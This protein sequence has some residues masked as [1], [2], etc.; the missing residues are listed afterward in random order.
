MNLP[1]D[2]VLESVFWIMAG[3]F[4]I[5]V[6]FL[7]IVYGRYAFKKAV[8]QP[9]GDMPPL[10]VVICAKN[11]FHNLSRNLPLI[12]DQN[13]PEYEVVVVDDASDDETLFYLEELK[14]KHPNL[15]V[16]RIDQDVN[17]FRGKKFPLSLGIKSAK[18]EYLLLTDADCTPAGRDWIKL[19]SAPWS[20]G[21]EVVL[22]YGPYETATGFLNKVIRFETAM[23]ALQYFSWATWGKPYMGVGRNL[24]YPR[25]LF[26]EA[27]GFTKHYQ[28]PS[29]DD[30]LFINQVANKSNTAIV[31][32]PDSFMISPP[33]KTWS[34]WWR[35]RTRHMDAGKFYRLSTRLRLAVYPLSL[36]LFY[37]S[38]IILF[39]TG[40]II[41]PA[42]M[43]IIRTV[44]FIAVF[45]FSIRKLHE[46]KLLL[47]SPLIEAGLLV[48]YPVMLLIKPKGRKL[49]WK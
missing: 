29:G 18:Y 17:F 25:K 45:Y 10:S 28:I 20:A 19:M 4:V 44:A 31:D 2:I 7:L 3:A 33:K 37:L 41:L 16:V 1:S 11:E 36:L 49:R 35:Q 42:I 14:Q 46:K 40:S 24:A 6:V 12:L 48:A 39:T 43:L 34:E 21:K 9:D 8:P 32:Q 22:G 27:G 26:L 38:A 30:D 13:Y 15:K 47:F 5:Q 23:T